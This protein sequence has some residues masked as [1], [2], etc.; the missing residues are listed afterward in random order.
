MIGFYVVLQI[1]HNQTALVLLLTQGHKKEEDKIFAINNE[2][3]RLIEGLELE[4][5]KN[6]T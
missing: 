4:N 3:K 6:K 5:E 2:T 1:S